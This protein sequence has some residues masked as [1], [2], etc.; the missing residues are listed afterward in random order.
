[1]ALIDLSRYA[2]PTIEANRGREYFEGEGDVNAYKAM[3][4]FGGNLA[5]IAIDLH[6]KEMDIFTH[7]EAT[8]ALEKMKL[9]FTTKQAYALQNIDENNFVVGTEKTYDQFIADTIDESRAAYYDSLTEPV[10]KTKFE[11]AAA[12]WVTGEKTQAVLK[13]SAIV[14]EN[15]IKSFDKGVSNKSNEVLYS[16]STDL[17][18]NLNDAFVNIR[19]TEG[20]ILRK[21]AGATVAIKKL[22]AAKKSLYESAMEASLRNM[23]DDPNSLHTFVQLSGTGVMFKNRGEFSQYVLQQYMDTFDEYPDQ[24]EAKALLDE[25]VGPE[26]DVGQLGQTALTTEGHPFSDLLS[27]EE[28]KQYLERMLSIKFK[29]KKEKQG[30]LKAQIEDWKAAPNIKP[31]TFV[32]LENWISE[33]QRLLNDPH[34]RGNNT[35]IVRV[36]YEAADKKIMQDANVY[37]LNKGAKGYDNFIKESAVKRDAYAGMILSGIM[38]PEEYAQAKKNNPSVGAK[39]A[40]TVENNL[41]ELQKN[42]NLKKNRDSMYFAQSDPTYSNLAHQAIQV[43]PSGGITINQKALGQLTTYTNQ[44]LK[45]V[46]TAQAAMDSMNAL[47]SKLMNDFSNNIAILPPDKQLDVFKQINA[48]NPQLATGL[49]TQMVKQGKLSLE[50]ASLAANAQVGESKTA[51][52]MTGTLISLNNKFTKQYEADLIKNMKTEGFLGKDK[53]YS[54]VLKELNN[55][56]DNNE[57]INGLKE[58]GRASGMTE[59]SINVMFAKRNLQLIAMERLSKTLNTEAS[60]GD[61]LNPWGFSNKIKGSL[62]EAVS[63]FYGSRVSP[64]V[65]DNIKVASLPNTISDPEKVKAR[66]TALAEKVKAGLSSGEL[67]V[68]FSDYAGMKKAEAYRGLSDALKQKYFLRD[69]VETVSFNGTDTTGKSQELVGMFKDP[70][71]GA[72]Y[73]IKLKTANGGSYVPVIPRAHEFEGYDEETLYQKYFSGA[74]NKPQAIAPNKAPISQ[75]KTK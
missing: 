38:S 10:S 51:D 65:G 45:R 33:G 37:L 39:Y 16:N 14:T 43:S 44:T 36:V 19:D 64:I 60:T 32:D 11:A 66:A 31:F 71:S 22:E 4:S 41:R 68:D 72:Y 52:A 29:N 5:N 20:E 54:D 75:R 50:Q 48:G 63:E 58:I 55:H 21:S 67:K 1:M 70:S 7:R 28:K 59:A 73:R 6:T 23:K 18:D 46:G 9:D 34:F 42:V 62:E 24:D 12:S 17:I 53:E 13:N 47:P 3:A 56:I 15:S 57:Y 8:N 26:G 74:V 35:D 61:K 69:V 40:L 49:Y 25:I 27:P 30:N 2:P